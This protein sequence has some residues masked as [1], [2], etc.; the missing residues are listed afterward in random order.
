MPLLLSK[1]VLLSWAW[2]SPLGPW[3]KLEHA[4]RRWRTPQ[5][6]PWTS[7]SLATTVGV[8]WPTTRHGAT[9][10]D[11]WRASAYA[12]LDSK[13][14]ET[15]NLYWFGPSWLSNSLYV[16][17]VSCLLCWIDWYDCVYKGC[18]VTLFI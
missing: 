17:S 16:Q 2:Y 5:E 18:A 9:Q 12:K 11:D 4:P 6:S 13:C 15:N 1:V 7:S 8:W 10:D 3:P 14:K